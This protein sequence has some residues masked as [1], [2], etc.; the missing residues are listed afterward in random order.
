MNQIKIYASEKEDGLSELIQNSV[1]VAY[2]SP[3]SVHKGKVKT[4]IEL[5]KNNEVKNRVIAENK[6]QPDLYYLE[7]VLVS[8][9]WNKNDDVFRPD[10]TWAARSTPEDKQF[11]FMHDENDIIGHITGSYILD[12]YG[13]RVSADQNEAPEEFDIITQA[14]LYNSWTNPE[15]AERMQKIISEIEE[16]KWFVSMECL[17]AGFDYAV[18]DQ[19][20]KAS[21]LERNDESSFLT[22][23]L[24]SYG[25]TGEYEGYKIGRALKHIAFSG[26]GLVSKPANPRSVILNKHPISIASFNKNIVNNLSIGEKVMTETT[27][28]EKQLTELKAELASAREENKAIK[29]KIEEANATK[30]ADLEKQIADS[31]QTIETLTTT[32]ADAIKSYEVKVAELQDQLNTATQ[33]LTAAKK[34][35][36]EMKK[37]EKM[38]KRMATL[39]EAGFEQ[40]EAEESLAAFQDLSDEL[41]ET[42]VAMWNK[43][44]MKSKSEE[45]VEEVKEEAPVTAEV[46]EKLETSEATLVEAQVNNEV[47]STRANIA[48][49]LE[50]H[51]L[52]KKK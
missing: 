27:N 33:E 52:T 1:S 17:F 38:Q 41:F 40:T 12:K 29:A 47:E 23:H 26:K 13:Q 24:R 28:L 8:T 45:T 15:N 35:M 9:G 3:V 32:Q 43:K 11:N 10:E 34:D 18:V 14:V 19:A 44:K 39:V 31:A 4:T 42:I 21:I 5:I 50:N 20:G 30:V 48:S 25:G 46:F 22:K 6:D 7:S 49:W 51:V 37:K 16:G 36:E 2:C